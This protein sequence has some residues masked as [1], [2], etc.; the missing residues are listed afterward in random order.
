MY[1]LVYKNFTEFKFF[2]IMGIMTCIQLEGIL[3]AVK[4]YVRLPLV[5]LKKTYDIQMDGNKN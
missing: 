3:C 4:W 2:M 5:P 1:E